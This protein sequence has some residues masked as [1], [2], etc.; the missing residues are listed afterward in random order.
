MTARHILDPTPQ[1]PTPRSAWCPDCRR[2]WHEADFPT[3]TNVRILFHRCLGT[4][5]N[6][7]PD[8]RPTISRPPSKEELIDDERKAWAMKVFGLS[9]EEAVGEAAWLSVDEEEL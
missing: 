3:D 2:T 1:D 5:E 8:R 6:R 4:G 7:P 9:F